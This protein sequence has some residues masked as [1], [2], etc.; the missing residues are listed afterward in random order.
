MIDEDMGQGSLCD[1]LSRTWHASALRCVMN[2]YLQLVVGIEKSLEGARN[3]VVR[4]SALYVSPTLLQPRGK[5]GKITRLHDYYYFL[6]G[7]KSTL[8][9]HYFSRQ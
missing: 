4:D 6:A 8:L 1:N 7:M 5:D 2:P 3:L 9:M